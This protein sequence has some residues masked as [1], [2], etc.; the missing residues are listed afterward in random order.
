MLVARQVL[1]GEVK[2]FLSNAPEDTPLTKVL[3]VAFSRHHIERLFEDAKG[4]VGLDHFEVRKYQPLMRH[5]VLSMVSL[6]FL[7]RQAPREGG[8]KITVECAPT[9]PRRRRAAGSRLDPAGATTKTPP[10]PHPDRC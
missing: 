4:Q 7:V 1:T 8:N 5:L 3:E 9:P 10:A 6:L 2:Y